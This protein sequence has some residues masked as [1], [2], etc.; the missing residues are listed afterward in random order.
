[1]AIFRFP[2]RKLRRLIQQGEYEAAVRFGTGLE[3]RFGEDADFLFIMGSLYYIVE[4]A[5]KAL[6]YFDRS[7]QAGGSEED[8]IGALH[9]KANVHIHL[10]EHAAA[11]ECC[12]K[13]LALDPR[14]AE[15]LQIT[16]ALEGDGDGE[17]E[18]RG[19]KQGPD[20]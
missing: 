7:L 3:P 15:A 18:K 2:K 6:H 16:G 12:R 5:Q 17:K 10:E 8:R 13:I 11:L 9:L 1:M 19:D 14:H 4:D 20:A